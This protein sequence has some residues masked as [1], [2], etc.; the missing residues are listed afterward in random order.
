MWNEVLASTGCPTME[1]I[2]GKTAKEIKDAAR[3]ASDGVSHPIKLILEP[4]FGPVVDGV[5]LFDQIQDAVKGM[6]R[7][8]FNHRKKSFFIISYL[9]IF[10]Q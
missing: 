7:T 1:C 3:A 2:R 9:Q 10:D 6:I 8:I 5:T 4:G